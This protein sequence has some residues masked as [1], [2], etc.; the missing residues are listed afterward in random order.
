MTQQKQNG[1]N[2][3]S[4]SVIA[5][6]SVGFREEHT[7]TVWTVFSV[8]KITNRNPR[9]RKQ[10]IIKKKSTVEK[11]L[12]QLLATHSPTNYEDNRWSW[13]LLPPRS[14]H[15][16]NEKGYNTNLSKKY[17]YIYKML[18]E[19]SEKKIETVNFLGLNHDPLILIML[20]ADGHSEVHGLHIKSCK[21]V[22]SLTT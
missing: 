17:L 19:C 13:P 16:N 9:E 1:W 7:K 15:E 8:M 5:W 11:F 12:T 14:S 6:L 10:L 18:L 3:I 2:T 20:Q 21:I 22:W 4:C